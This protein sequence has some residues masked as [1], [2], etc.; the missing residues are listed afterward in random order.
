MKKYNL[1]SYKFTLA[2]IFKY[3]PKFA[4]IKNLRETLY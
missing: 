2:R 1:F 4:N 3:I